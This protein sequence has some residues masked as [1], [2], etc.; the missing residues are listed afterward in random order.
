MIKLLIHKMHCAAGALYTILEGLP[1]GVESGKGRQQRRVNIEDSLRKSTDKLRREQAHISG[2]AHEVDLMLSQGLNNLGFVLCSLTAVGFDDQRREA[3]RTGRS[4][5]GRVGA[6]GDDDRD[7]RSGKL[8]RRDAVGD[9][10]EIRSS[11]GE[12]DSQLLVGRD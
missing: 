9:G 6:I 5:A 12:Q 11:T 7:L 8:S 1:L 3:T 2:E 4:D 10:E